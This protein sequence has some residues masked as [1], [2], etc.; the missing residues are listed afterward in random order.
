MKYGLI[1]KARFLQVAI[2]ITG[3]IALQPIHPKRINW[4]NT[5]ERAWFPL[6]FEEP[7]QVAGFCDPSATDEGTFSVR[8]R[9]AIIRRHAH[10]AH[11]FSDFLRRLEG[12]RTHVLPSCATVNVAGAVGVM[13]E[14]EH[15]S[16]GGDPLP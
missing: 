6:T 7:N 1:I 16:N 14:M 5:E 10:A 12:C 13:R 11:A 2:G 15:Q 4:V 8:V 3:K 9:F